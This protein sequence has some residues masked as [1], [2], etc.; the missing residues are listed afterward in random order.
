CQGWPAHD[1]GR[2][3]VS[4]A[5]DTTELS[6]PAAGGRWAALLGALAPMALA[7]LAGAGVLLVLGVDPLAFYANVVQRGLLTSLG[8][9]ATVTP[10]A[11]LLLLGASLIVAFRAGLW[12]LGID[13]QF[14]LGA[15]MTAA[16]CPILITIMPNWAMVVTMLLIA[17]MVGALWSVIPALLKA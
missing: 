11:P 13:G 14:I 7:L 6:T 3:R 2:R 9:Q 1:R 5:A 10:M 4:A 17:A 8:L 12:N 16:L 15:V